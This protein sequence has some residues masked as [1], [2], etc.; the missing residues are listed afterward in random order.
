MEL[1]PL[2]YFSTLADYLSFTEAAKALFITQSTLSLSIKQLEDEL[3]TKLF[4]RVGKRIYLTDAGKTFLEYARRAISETNNGIE[5][6]KEMQHIYT[7]R[8]R[9]GVIYSSSVV[10]NACIKNFTKT[11]PQ[12][13]LSIFYSHSILE[14]VEQIN[15][16]NLDFA[17]T[18]KPDNIPPLIEVREFNNP[19]LCI[20]AHKDHPISIRK[21]FSLEDIVNHPLIL[22]PHG[23]YTRQII[24]RMLQQ[25][26]IKVRPQLEINS[27]PVILD[28]LHRGPWISILSKDS[29]RNNPDLKAIP[30]KGISECMHASLL[31][32]KGKRQSI[33][34][35]KLLEMMK[36]YAQEVHINEEKANSIHEKQSI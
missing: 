22:F 27:T 25:N 5:K 3:G 15:A 29:T 7:G 24:D 18:Y 28:L 33:L 14:L 6:L 31:F 23:I 20:V 4:D 9:V 2:K 10:L 21:S 8:V 12:A 16:N 26:N 34:A 32:L 35:E 11:F 1:T 17:V 30:I 36:T 19:P 13:Q